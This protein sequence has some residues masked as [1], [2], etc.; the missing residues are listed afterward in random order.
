MLIKVLLVDDEMLVRNHLRS[1]FDWE[2]QGFTLCGEANNG[3]AALRLIEALKPQILILD[4]HMPMMDGVEL[5]KYVYD[6]YRNIQIIVLSS[7]DKYEYVRDT[8]KHGAIDYLLKSRIQA[9]DLIELLNKA[10]ST[11]E[12][13]LHDQPPSASQVWSQN[14]IRLA[15]NQ[16]K[17]WVLGDNERSAGLDS[18]YQSLK[19]TGKQ[20]LVVIMQI[21]N[22]SVI[23]EGYSDTDKHQ[24]IRSILNLSQQ[25]LGPERLGI[26]SHID[27][28]KFLLL[29]SVGQQH[30]E[31]LAISELHDS[32][33]RLGKTVNMYLNVKAAFGYSPI[34]VQHSDIRKYYHSACAAMEQNLMDIY[35][36]RPYDST[37]NSNK[38]VSLMTINITQ[39][40]D[41]LSALERTDKEQT[42]GILKDIF[43]QIQRTSTSPGSIQMIVSELVSILNKVARKTG[44]EQKSLFGGEFLSREQLNQYNNLEEIQSWIQ[45]AYFNL[46]DILQESRYV[47]TYSKYVQQAIKYVNEF[48]KHP[49]SLEEVAEKA[50]I[51]PSYL[52]RLFKEETQTTFTDYLNQHRIHMSQGLIEHG[53]ERIKDIYGKVGFSSYNYF[54]KVFKDIVGM[55]P[56]EYAKSFETR[57]KK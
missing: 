9:A 4:I 12:S 2:N 40:K 56:M 19:A 46:T 38:S 16:L 49:L 29:L 13:G 24:Y 35:G 55:T 52:S 30:S 8:M 51:T 37:R 17:D 15:Q 28:G 44:I 54:F 22:F 33:E 45:G 50:G 14:G 31:S 10:R 53:D 1:L 27:Q 57:K 25:A 36:C 18:L 20:I 5:T 39:E 43:E 26:G 23:T 21:V 42:A 47:G 32:I 3:A 11:I 7:Y 6:K 48:Y 34:C 41:L